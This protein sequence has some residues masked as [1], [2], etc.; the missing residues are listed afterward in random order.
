M[1][2]RFALPAWQSV[3]IAVI[4]SAFMT[5]RAQH[6][7]YS[8]Q[9]E[10]TAP[11]AAPLSIKVNIY[12]GNFPA[13]AGWNN[14]NVQSHLSF[15]ELLYT[16]GSSSS[17][18]A[19]MN[20]SNAIADNGADFPVTMC[21]IDVGRTA[22]YSTVARFITL[23]GLDNAKQYDLEVYASR[24]GTGNTTKFTVGSVSVNVLTDRNYNTKAVFTDIAPVS[25]QIRLNIERL[26]T[27]NYIN[28]FILKESSGQPVNTLPVSVPGAGQVITLPAAQV[29]LNGSSSYDP[30]GTITAYSWKRITGPGT[31]S[32]ANPGNAS[33]VVS[34]F[35]KGVHVFRLTVTDNKGDSSGNNVQVQVNEALPPAQPGSSDSL[36]CG[37]AFKIVVLGSSTAMGS[38]ATPI[39]SAWANK[40]RRYVR[41]KNVQSN[42][43]NLA[44]SGFTTYHVLCPTGFVP[45]AN[46]PA[47]DTAHNI[48]KA[49]THNPDLIIINLP[50]ND[51]QKSF[52]VAEQQAN[53]ERM[54]SVINAL[55]IPVWVTTTQPRNAM[56]AA[57]MN[58][59]TT[60]RDWTY[61]RFGEKAIDFWTDIASPDGTVNP[62]YNVD[63]VH[64]N[65]NAHHILYT[66]VLAEH[67]LDTLCLRRNV[68]PVANAGADIAVSQP[69][70]AQLHGS[71]SADPDGA[72]VSYQ[73]N[74][75]SG[76]AAYSISNPAI[77]SPQLS[78]LVTGVYGFELTVK[79]NMGATAKDT[80]AITVNSLQL[81]DPVASAGADVTITLP[82]NS[83][84][85]NAGASSDPD[86]RIV[87]YNW[88]KMSGPAAFAISNAAAVDPL[89]SGLT[90]GTYVI[91]LTV[92]DNDNRRGEDLVT[93][94]VKPAAN[95]APT[96]NAGSDLYITL[97]QNSITVDA[98]ASADNDGV[99]VSYQWTK[100]TGPVSFTISDGAI[101]NPVI[102]NLT[103]GTYAIELVVTDDD[104]AIG[105]DTVNVV[106]NPGT[107]GQLKK[108]QVNVY[109]GTLPAGTG[110]NNWN[111]Q[112]SLSLNSTFYADGTASPVTATLNVSNAIADNGA[113]YPA[114]MCPVEVGRTT[115]YSTVA[116]YLVLS[117]LDNA[118]T[119]ELE[120]YASRN[121]TGNATKFS[122]G[123]VSKNVST[124]RN[125]GNKVV[126]SGIRPVGGQVRLMIERLNTYNYLNGF[127]LSETPGISNRSSVDMQFS[128]ADVQMQ[129]PEDTAYRSFTISPN[130]F[131]GYIKVEGNN[132]Y[133]GKMTMSLID[134][135][136]RKLQE[137]VFMKETD[138]VSRAFQTGELRS[139]VYF[140]RVRTGDKM[141][142]IKVVKM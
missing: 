19:T 93:V 22:S 6:P 60:M 126:F 115:S 137:V 67:L 65:N 120:V 113:G 63:G 116:R 3:C 124:D 97:P 100:I 83:I 54:M 125:Y 21:P 75:I 14:W 119:Y 35:T 140:I 57:Q 139:G 50:S 41:A 4:L 102:S 109:G 118:K 110:W 66:R 9:K 74:R 103:E 40:L 25:G 96:A 18:K 89:I 28:G 79:D 130:P 48:T 31:V 114:T 77:A 81:Q 131:S 86:G 49:L 117:G 62:L 70:P 7:F 58:M 33:T 94:T 29:T 39:D 32:I 34:G 8:P 52:P 106:V 51:A 13:G 38:G 5:A 71:L 55:N 121:G 141:E 129:A 59:L 112:S 17:I 24:A 91:K 105:K 36:N 27:Y 53:Y 111:V 123:T 132:R 45:P 44:L 26:N 69:G 92:T 99:I 43:I 108:I 73:W 138:F 30:D 20:L 64:V 133:R 46:R 12:G 101:A 134:Q 135:S 95:I 107:S 68:R 1:K 42:V 16:D 122:V 11:V 61:Q 127:T 23:S 15:D 10:N 47:P 142:V 85:L 128:R 90:A 82:Q 37:K 136:G 56:S 76:P 2:I 84:S 72:I 80:V 88:T 104:G 78:G 98:G 87:S